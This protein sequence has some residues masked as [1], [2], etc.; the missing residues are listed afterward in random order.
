M[1]TNYPIILAHGICPFDGIFAALLR[2]DNGTRDRYHYFKNIRTTLRN[3]G[4]E[5]FHARVSWAAEMDRRAGE[6][7]DEILCMTDQFRKWPRVHIIAHSMGG[8]DSRWMIYRYQMDNRVA[9]LTT[10]GAPHHGTSCAD[11]GLKR[12]GWLIRAAGIIGLNIR[13][14]RDL[15]R[16]SCAERN[17]M[18]ADFE[19]NNAVCYQTVSGVQP[20][21][22]IFLPLRP[23]F[24]VIWKNEGENDG[25]VSLR[26][27][28]WKEKYLVA[29]IDAD[30]LNQ[31]GW[32]DRGEAKSGMD[33]KSF[34]KR[35]QEVYLRIARGLTDP[36]RE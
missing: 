19:E 12:S 36:E 6:L 16:D 20:I 5:V 3:H 24:R 34:E 32:W 21:E 4:F 18:M 23:S 35:I 8:L 25:L 2:W 7:R 33:R 14:F 26:S 17:R 10:I 28:M 9:S 30:H 15:T 27:S 29:K 13:G 31:I 11:W 22:R 1:H